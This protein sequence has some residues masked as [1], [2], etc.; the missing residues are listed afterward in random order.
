VLRQLPTTG[1]RAN[2]GV[3]FFCFLLPSMLTQC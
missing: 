1:N 2:L 3:G